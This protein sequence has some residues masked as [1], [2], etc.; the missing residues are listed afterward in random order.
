M[1]EAASNVASFRDEV[2]LYDAAVARCVRGRGEVAVSRTSGS[3][4]EVQKGAMA[5][6]TEATEGMGTSSV[7]REK[8]PSEAL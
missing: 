3:V 7:A 1:A 4:L 5:G 8:D 6:V 2:S